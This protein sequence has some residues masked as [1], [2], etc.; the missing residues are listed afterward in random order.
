MV[1]ETKKHDRSKS[2]TNGHSSKCEVCP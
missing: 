1:N 2:V